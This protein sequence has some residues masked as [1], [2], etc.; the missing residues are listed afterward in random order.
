MGTLPGGNLTDV[1]AHKEHEGVE[2]RAEEERAEFSVLGDR[3]HLS[4]QKRRHPNTGGVPGPR[5][6][7]LKGNTLS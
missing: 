1:T 7:G 4:A 6:D 3:N 2:K 5:L